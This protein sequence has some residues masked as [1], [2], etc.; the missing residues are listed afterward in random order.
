MPVTNTFHNQNWSLKSFSFQARY[1][2]HN[3]DQTAGEESS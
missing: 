1:L 2:N 3:K